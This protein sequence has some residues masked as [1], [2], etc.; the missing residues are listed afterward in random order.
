MKIDI[1]TLFPE[2]LKPMLSESILGRAIAAGLLQVRLTD[3]REFTADRHRRADDYPFGGGA[4]MVMAA[5]P[6]ADAIAARDPEHRAR[7]IYLSPRGRK[8]DQRV[9]EELAREPQLLL[10]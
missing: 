4:G 7:R 1:L 9:V 5:Q 3:I 8:L 10:L 2:M 6:I